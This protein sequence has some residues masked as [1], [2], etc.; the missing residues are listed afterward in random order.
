M[1]LGTLLSMLAGIKLV[2]LWVILLLLPP[3]A[4]EALVLVRAAVLILI[5]E[6]S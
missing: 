4:L 6:L 1:G 3:M 5:D 2:V